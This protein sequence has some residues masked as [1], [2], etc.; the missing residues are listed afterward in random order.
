VAKELSVFVDESGDWG[1][2]DYHPLCIF[3]SGSVRIQNLFQRNGRGHFLSSFCIGMQ[4]IQMEPGFQ[5]AVLIFANCFKINNTVCL[6]RVS[7]PGIDLNA[8]WLGKIEPCEKFLWVNFTTKS[9]LG[10]YK[11]NSRP[12]SAKY[13]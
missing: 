8:Q 9:R 4:A 1:E 11:E 3:L 10:I 6:R 5:S 7:D 13:A 2:Y 12:A